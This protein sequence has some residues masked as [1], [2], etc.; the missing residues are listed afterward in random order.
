[1]C[2]LAPRERAQCPELGM[3]ACGSEL[4]W[5]ETAQMAKI[6]DLSA[7]KTENVLQLGSV[8]MRRA[9]GCPVSQKMNLCLFC[10]LLEI[11]VSM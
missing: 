2:F 3:R 6:L 9:E 10:Q 7:K 1:M 5:P 11:G 8:S 4:I